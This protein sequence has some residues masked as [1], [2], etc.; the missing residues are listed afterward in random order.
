MNIKSFLL[1]SFLGIAL[2]AT[3][4]NKHSI[5]GT[6]ESTFET[7]VDNLNDVEITKDTKYSKR[8]WVSGITA[9][10]K[11]YAILKFSDDES[12]M[13]TIPAQK[14]G[15]RNIKQGNLMYDYATTELFIDNNPI[16]QS[17]SIST[18]KNGVSI[19]DG[20]GVNV[21]S[22]GEDGDVYVNDGNGRSVKTDKDG[23]VQIHNKPT[24]NVINYTGYK[25]GF[26]PKESLVEND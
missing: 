24:N 5:V 7:G 14:V 18:G 11:I 23:G 12:A 3:A 2:T 1:A 10:G 6:Y 26:K 4:Q 17:S 13:Y 22:T 25:K 8:I 16:F 19:K 15:N 20:N 21:V 9:Q